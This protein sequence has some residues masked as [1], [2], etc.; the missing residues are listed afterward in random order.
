M[1]IRSVLSVL[2]IILALIARAQEDCELTLTQATEEFQAGHFSS[3]PAILSQCIDK[4]STEQQQRAN[5]L[6]T[7]T[8]LLLDDPIG[9]KSSYLAVLRANPEFVADPAIHPVD[10]VYLSKKFTASPIFSWFV[11]AGANVTPI[12]VIHDIDAYGWAAVNEEYSLN[13]GYQ[14]SGGGDLLVREPFSLRGEIGYLYCSYSHKATNYFQNDTKTFRENMGWFNA[15]LTVMYSREVGQ[16]RPFGYLGYAFSYL[17]RDRAVIE[18]VRIGSN[19]DTGKEDKKSPN[20]NFIDKRN[21]VNTS[22]VIGGGVKAKFGLQYLFVDVRYTVGLKNIVS[23]KNLY[24]DN[25]ANLTS[26]G[27]LNSSE[28]VTAYGHVDD[29]FR[30]DNFSIS[31]GFIQPLYK[32]REIKKVRGKFL[33]KSKNA[34]GE[35]TN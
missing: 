11:K 7:Q 34:N 28:S 14:F 15:P 3:I 1:F 12:R 24:A 9:A 22:V 4:F 27:Y 26:D 21:R 2:L 25:S 20:V 32:P 23:S 10:V 35:K 5:L 6:L 29:F 31:V 16:Y 30:I 19:E 18:A 17:L 13:G 33:F 8:Y